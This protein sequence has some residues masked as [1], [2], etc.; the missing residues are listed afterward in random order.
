[1]HRQVLIRLCL[2]LPLN[3]LLCCLLLPYVIPPFPGFS[4]SVM[5]EVLLWQMISA[6]GWPLALIGLAISLP[7][8][9]RTSAASLLPLFIYPVIEFLFIRSLLSKTSRHIDFILLH[10]FVILSFILMW[11]AVLNGYDF[12]PG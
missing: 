2:S 4:L 9:A 6:V 11:Y 1:M 8:G 7:F 12:M 3:I 5:L 10:I